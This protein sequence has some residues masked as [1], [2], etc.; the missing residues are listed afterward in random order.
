MTVFFSLVTGDAPAAGRFRSRKRIRQPSQWEKNI[1]KKKKATGEEY[2]STAGKFVASQPM[3]SPCRESCRKKCYEKF[4]EE[5]RRII[6]Q[7]YINLR[8]K[9][10]IKSFVV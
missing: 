6:Y 5:D 2:V 1:R 4:A 3:R 10:K 7:E 8:Q 9:H